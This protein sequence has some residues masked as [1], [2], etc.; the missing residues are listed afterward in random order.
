FQ[1]MAKDFVRNV[2]FPRVADYV[3]SSTR[4]GAEAFLKAIRRPR[5]MFEYADDDLG[6][7]PT[8]WDDYNEGKISL[9]QAVERSRTAV[10]SSIQVVDHAASA[11]DVVPDVIQNEQFLQNAATEVALDL[12]PAPAITRQEVA[13]SAK[14]LVIDDNEPALRGYRCFLA[15]TDKAREEMGEFFLQPHRTSVVWGGQKTLFIFLHHSGQFGLYYD[16][17]TREPVEAPAGGGSFPT[18]TIVLKDRLF[19]PIPDAIRAS[20]IPTQGERKRFEVRADILRT[21]SSD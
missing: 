18:A 2:I 16:L 10:R 11:R 20:F 1:S 6:S 4:Q 21:D 17:Q 5:E 9:D 14:L 3:P 8:I 12:E 19:I 7:L 13:T 15:I